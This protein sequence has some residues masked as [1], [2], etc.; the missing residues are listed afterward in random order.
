MTDAESLDAVATGLGSGRERRVRSP[1]MVWLRRIAI[2]LFLLAIVSGAALLICR[3]YGHQRLQDELQRVAA[4]QEVLDLATVRATYAPPVPVDENAAPLWLQAFTLQGAAESPLSFLASAEITP[5]LWQQAREF[6]LEHREVF[7]AAREAASRPSCRFAVDPQTPHVVG[8]VAEHRRMFQFLLSQARLAVQDGDTVQAKQAMECLLTFAAHRMQPMTYIDVLVGIRY[9]LGVTKVLPYYLAM[10]PPSEDLQQL[11]DRLTTLEID[12]VPAFVS[13]RAFIHQSLRRD[14]QQAEDFGTAYSLARL[15]GL[16][17]ID[18]AYYLAR[19]DD[20]LAALRLPPQQVLAQLG[21]LDAQLAARS[22]PPKFASTA[23]SIV[24]MIAKRCLQTQARLA[25][26][27]AAL[28]VELERVDR[29]HLPSAL[30]LDVTD[31]FSGKPLIYKRDGDRYLL[32]SVGDNGVDDGG[33]REL[34]VVFEAVNRTVHGQ[35][36]K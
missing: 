28:D 20:Y 4:T 8:R 21:V 10:H 14:D 17:D 13:E 7:F 31:P 1:A 22:F 12:I 5:A 9:W 18:H 16:V 30:A 23:L 6:H 29:G 3:A 32:Y 26:S 33:D 35:E 15:F 2:I 34:D 11:Q 25:V 36:E 19:C 27:I 24:S